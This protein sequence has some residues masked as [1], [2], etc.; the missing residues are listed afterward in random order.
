MTG[1][2][3]FCGIVKE[4]HLDQ[5]VVEVEQRANFGPG[6]ALQFM[7]PNGNTVDLNLVNL[8]DGDG[9]SLD[10]ARHPRQRVF[11]PCEAQV[12]EYSILRRLGKTYEE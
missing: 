8:L 5:G 2:S 3:D 4:S 10:R 12:P 7:L 11:I 1:R 6:E 9:N